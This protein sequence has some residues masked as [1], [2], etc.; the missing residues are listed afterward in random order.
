MKT[1]SYVGRKYVIEIEQAYSANMRKG[2]SDMVDPIKLYK[3]K[4]FNSLVFDEQ[5][6]DKLKRMPELEQIDARMAQIDIIEKTAYENGLHDAWEIAK[7]IECMDGYDSD[8]LIE[9]FG[10]D[11]IES[12]FKRYTASEVL[13]KVKAY[14]EQK[15]KAF[16]N[17]VEVGDEIVVKVP[18]TNREISGIIYKIE[19]DHAN[20]TLMYYCFSFADSHVYIIPYDKT[21]TKTGRHFPQ[22]TSLM[23]K[24]STP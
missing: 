2:S 18:H 11:G 23:S 5:G 9:M 19:L 15:A 4:G 8:E 14:E 12:I 1:N 16:N 3:V 6:L 7:K 17:A 20:T 22:I 10:T 21:I 24:I 13:E